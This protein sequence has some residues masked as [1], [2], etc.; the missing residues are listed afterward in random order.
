MNPGKQSGRRKE[1]WL[2]ERRGEFRRGWSYK[3]ARVKL[4][5]AFHAPGNAKEQNAMQ[6]EG[7]D[8]M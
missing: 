3:G 6:V 4:S 8:E 5:T 7:K 1:E 2:E